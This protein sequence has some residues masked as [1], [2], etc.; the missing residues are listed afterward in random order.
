MGAI[1]SAGALVNGVAF[2]ASGG[3]VGG[4]RLVEIAASGGD[5]ESTIATM[6]LSRGGEQS[7]D[8]IRERVRADKAL[9]VGLVDVFARLG[10]HEVRP[11]L[12][13]I[14]GSSDEMVAG[15]ARRA[16]EALSAD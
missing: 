9:S 12:E 16:I 11:E 8:L 14:V 15:R 13:D 2:A 1:D 10:G 5:D 3:R 4:D 6:F 7:V